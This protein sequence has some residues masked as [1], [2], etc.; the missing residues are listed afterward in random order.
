M[1]VHRA[2]LMTLDQDDV[3]QVKEAFKWIVQS[4]INKELG[5]ITM[6]TKVHGPLAQK[7]TMLCPELM[8]E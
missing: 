6:V 3:I 5:G 7:F 8:Q 1:S 2:K 4:H